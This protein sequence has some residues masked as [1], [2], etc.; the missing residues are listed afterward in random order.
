MRNAAMTQAEFP[1]P[2]INAMISVL[3][4]SSRTP[5]SCLYEV[6]R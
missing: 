3:D 5:P 2:Q 4:D 6:H 1:N